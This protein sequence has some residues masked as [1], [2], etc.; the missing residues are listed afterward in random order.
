VLDRDYFFTADE[1]KAWGLI[2]HVYDH[3]DSKAA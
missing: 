2:D 1:A 3:R